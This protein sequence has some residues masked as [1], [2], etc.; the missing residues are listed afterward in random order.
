MKKILHVIAQQ[1]GKT[2]SGIFAKNI[3][4]QA[5]KKGY[6][7]TLIAGVPFYEN[8]KAYCLPEGVCF[9]P[10]IFESSQLPFPVVGMSDEMPYESTRYD[11][12]TGE[13]FELWEKNF[14]L[15][16]KEAVE[17]FEPDVVLTHHLWLL[18]S[19]VREEIPELPV[20]AFSHGSDLRQ[21][22]N[23]DR[24]RM[25][26]ISSCK[27]LDGIFA[28]N[29]FQK[30][31]ICE[32]Y[33]VSPEIVKI[34]GAGYDRNC[35]NED[36]WEPERKPGQIVYA[37]KISKAKGVKSL[38]DA[39]EIVSCKRP[40]A[41]LIIAGS[42]KGMEYESL[43]GRARGM[44]GVSLMGNMDQCD[45]AKLFRQSGVF[46]LPSFYE[47]LPLVLAEAAAC[48]M[49]LVVSELGGLKEW[50]G[51]DMM[52]SQNSV[53]VPLPRMVSVDK[54]LKQDEYDYAQRFADALMKQIDRYEGTADSTI[55]KEF[56]KR[57]SWESVFDQI[58]KHIDGNQRGQASLN[59]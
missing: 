23:N 14:G 21:M 3:L 6:N 41:A 38:L 10:V 17:S 34:T 52:V 30:R 58:E 5:D 43:A 33:N 24:H 49:K 12:L 59:H 20:F 48:G 4:H 31:R 29:D 27:K 47:G 56:V 40:N 45:L 19:L 51:Q 50:F 16:L 2:G 44:K 42:G 25:R 22:E 46:A 9:E 37:G 35:F 11:E 53:T 7:Q 26:V 8:K 39:F 1:P 13:K 57:K 36:H 55:R 32:F 28:L 15:S 18:T 54:P